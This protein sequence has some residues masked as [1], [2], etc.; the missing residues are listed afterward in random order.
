MV[1]MR[2]VI[3]L[4]GFL[5]ITITLS[6]PSSVLAA[7]IYPLNSCT[8]QAKQ[9]P[10]DINVVTYNIGDDND[11]CE[12]CSAGQRIGA[13]K[14]LME[15]NYADI[16]ALQELDIADLNK[17]HVPTLRA[18]LQAVL[19][20]FQGY[21]IIYRGHADGEFVEKG[22]PNQGYSYGNALITKL[23]V[24]KES[25]AEYYLDKHPG[26]GQ[27]QRYF[28]SIIVDTPQGPVRIY[29]IH[30]RAAE[31]GWGVTEAAKFLARTAANEKDLPFIVLGDFNQNM[32]N[33]Q[34]QLGDPQY[35]LNIAFGC[36]N[37]ALCYSGGID[38]LFPNNKIELLN[39][40]RGSAQSNG[41]TISGPH[42]PVY[43][44]FRL[45]KPIVSA[46]L[47]GNGTVDIFDYNMLLGEFG[48][49]GSPGFHPADI[50]KNG[51]VD[52]FDYNELLKAL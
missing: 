36:T 16:I 8:K 45:M 6:F 1:C 38:L 44:T 51:S 9:S 31:S 28:F 4:L 22:K 11:S 35:G 52:I 3:L 10:S 20:L 48:K 34:S 33:I 26:D 43:G 12:K 50:I 13:L 27:A 47:D 2:A 37:A 40:C 5:C 41:L 29:N 46:D 15:R 39:R 21:N 17:H 32:P 14:D 42:V 23:P 7:N 19:E 49:T 25:Y 30:T 24:R 18:E